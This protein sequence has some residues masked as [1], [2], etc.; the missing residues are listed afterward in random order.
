M[1]ALCA[2]TMGSHWLHEGRGLSLHASIFLFQRAGFRLQGT[3]FSPSRVLIGTRRLTPA[4]YSARTLLEAGWEAATH[5]RDVQVRVE[6]FAAGTSYRSNRK[7]VC[8]DQIKMVLGDAPYQDNSPSCRCLL[9]SL[10]SVRTHGW[11]S[12]R[13]LGPLSRSWLGT[14]CNQ[15][16]APPAPQRLL[17]TGPNW[18][19]LM[20]AG[21]LLEL[22][23]L[24][25]AP[26]HP[27]QCFLKPQK[28]CVNGA[29]F[30]RSAK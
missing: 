28:V 23:T 14:A 11:H 25:G 4:E 5:H 26:A 7:Q 22:V 17:L 13:K 20:Q 10:I 2:K 9:Q 21:H 8:G 6:A 29:T 3:L 15:L 24:L 18:T 30:K 27:C 1:L 19:M 12:H 16:L